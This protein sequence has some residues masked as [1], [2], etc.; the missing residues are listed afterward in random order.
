MKR[1]TLGLVMMAS[2]SVGLLASTSVLAGF[3][4][5][6]QV[7][8]FDA[9]Q[10]ANGNLGYARNTSD[11]TQSIGCWNDGTTGHCYA[12]NSAG[13]YRQCSTSDPGMLAAIRSLNGDSYLLFYWNSGGQCTYIQVENSSS[14]TPKG[15]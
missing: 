11:A 5:A 4:T 2:T 1:F 9:G 12:A 10:F 7:F 13:I 8:I 6:Q 15:P 3:K 14:T